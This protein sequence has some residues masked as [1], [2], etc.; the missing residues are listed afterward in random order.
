MIDLHCH[1][2]PGLDD[3]AQDPDQSLEMARIAAGDGISGIVCTPHLSP[4]FPANHRKTILA[5]LE[6]LRSMLREAKIRL[7]LYPGSELSIQS[8]LPERIESGEVLSINDTGKIALIEMP[9]DLFSPNLD[10]FFWRVRA[11]GIETVLA[12]PERNYHFMKDPSVLFQLVQA[13]VMVQ[14]TSASLRGL[15]GREIRD[16][17]LKLLRHRMVHFVSTDAHSP[18]RRSPRLSKARAI[19]ESVAGA[20]QAHKIFCEY[21]LLVLRGE[22][23]DLESPIPFKNRMSLVRRIFQFK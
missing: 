10:K 21:P 5:A 6:E 9:T 2:L 13:G 22:V 23:P 11:K 12:H 16:F 20:E 1:I 15:Y 8:N 4:V 18:E 19:T 17:S 7:D 3:G 14:I